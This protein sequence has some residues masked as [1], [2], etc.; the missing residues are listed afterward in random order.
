MPLTVTFGKHKGKPLTDV[1]PGY[2]DWAASNPTMFPWFKRACQEE[3]SRRRESS[4]RARRAWQRS[5]P[6]DLPRHQARTVC[7]VELDEIE[8]G[9]L[10]QAEVAG[11]LVITP[12]M[13]LSSP[14]PLAWRR[15]CEEHDVPHRVREV[16]IAEL[17]AAFDADAAA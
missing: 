13:P 16:T 6:D 1:P 5:M 15:W 14:V 2:L 10:R 17:M 3:L 12:D 11:E 7:G 8:S 9:L 4:N